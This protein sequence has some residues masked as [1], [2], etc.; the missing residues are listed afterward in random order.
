MAS[1][2]GIVS[3][4]L[5]GRPL[6]ERTYLSSNVQT[7]EVNTYDPSIYSV[8]GPTAGFLVELPPLAI[9]NN[10]DA[11]ENASVN[12]PFYQGVY[13]QQSAVVINNSVF[14]LGFITSD[15]AYSFEL[16]VT[17]SIKMTVQSV[18][19]LATSTGVAVTNMN[20]GDVWYPYAEKTVELLA[21]ASGPGIIQTQFFIKF[22]EDPRTYYLSIGGARAGRFFLFDP[23][24]AEG[25]TV[26]R[27]FLTSVFTSQSMTETRKVLRDKPLRSIEASLTYPNKFGAGKAWSKLRD[28][29]KKETVHPWYP[30][31]SSMTQGVGGNRVYCSVDYRRFQVGGY[32]FLVRN[33]T[34]AGQIYSEIVLITQMLADGFLTS[35]PATNAYS[36]GDSV[37][38]AFVC[39]AALSG[40]TQALMTDHKGTYSLQAEEVYGIN[41]LDV[42]NAGYSPTI[43]NSLP[44]LDLET[45]FTENPE[46]EVLMGGSSSDSGRGIAQITRGVPYVTQT[47][48]VICLFKESCWEAVGFFNYLQGRGKPFWAKSQLDFLNVTGTSGNTQFSIDNLNTVDDMDYLVYVWVEDSAGSFDVLAV[49][50][51][52]EGAS[53]VEITIE[54]NSLIDITKVH[55]AHAV[56]MAD[57]VV[58]EEYIT[59]NK[60]LATFTVQE[61]QGI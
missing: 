32:A 21:T 16:F 35:S 4:G 7:A 29:S 44:V 53:G 42:E 1:F 24:W 31:R 61:L 12:S 50:D 23:N 17:H 34:P 57:D 18:G 22:N 49:T 13:F 54:A 59:D 60:M 28:A 41:T 2:K 14:D 46:I 45:T 15:T 20:P 8:D 51:R 36:T 37:Y 43:R 48:T 19:I 55:Q 26:E 52:Q 30:D 9:V 39:Y 11:L 56:R 5:I 25:I 33:S 6:D 40:N 38:P 27:R 3:T 10:Y 47:A 58:T